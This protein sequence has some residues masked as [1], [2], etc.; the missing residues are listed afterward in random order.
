MTRIPIY[1]VTGAAGFVGRHV[2]RRLTNS[3]FEIRA[4][5]RYADVELTQLGVKLWFGDLWDGD[6][7]REAISDAN[8]I[9]HCAG[10]ARFGNGP[11]YYR[12]N[13]ELTEHLIHAT[14][15]YAGKVS[16][17][18]YVSTVGAVDR[19]KDDPSVTP[20][21]EDSPA[22]PTSDYGKS[23]LQA[24]EVVR[25]SDLPF[26]II[27]PTMVVG[28]D[29]RFDS[30]FAV[31]ARHSLRGS[32]VA[33]LAWTGSFSVVHVDD[34]ANAILTI[35]THQNA[36]GHTYFCAGE[37]ISIAD[38]FRQCNPEKIRISL[39]LIPG[40]ARPFIK[41][42]PFALKAM[43]FPALTASDQRL[44]ALGW[45]PRHSAR[46]ALEE[47]ITREKSRL[48]PDIS[49]GGQTV[50][51]G[52]ASGLG[53][54]LAM[55]LSPRREHL[56]L[57]D[58]NGVA[59]EELASS[60]KN[61]AVSVV[62]LADEADVDAMLTSSKWNAFNITELYACAGV[63]LRGRMQDISI[64]NHRKMFAI[65]VLARIALAKTAISSMQKRHFGRIVLIS[66]S[67]AFQPLPYMATY[68][69][70]NSAL[71]SIGESWGA[72]VAKDNIQILTVCP[73]GMQTNFQKSGGV[74]E[75]EGEKLM[76]PDAVVTE[77]INGLRKQR[78]T[79]MVS[80]RSFA[81]SML[82]RCLPRSS[83]VKLWYRLMEKMR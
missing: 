25:Y 27:R 13:V 32:W 39:S 74:R 73:G 75:I 43:L 37:A 10:D 16:R 28:D 9:I 51:T 8:V 15:K 60:L 55:Y 44:R 77:I 78:K 34:L 19:A 22:F 76:T 45:L 48:D 11:H 59:L 23:K 80:F 20:L 71:L 3:G 33:R 68:A 70:T 2:C 82:A 7:L 17:F 18:V 46:S 12:T 35:A 30:H 52:A 83:S 66:S 36:I 63:G 49:P 72:E 61:C 29:M 50:I 42:M 54:A 56:L 65:N 5:V 4:M 31:F 1:F 26:A 58:K 41:W 57:I 81:M 40:A 69:A 79:L 67:S 62:D 64:D 14:K 6:I 38:F 24:E 53:R 47:V 21:T